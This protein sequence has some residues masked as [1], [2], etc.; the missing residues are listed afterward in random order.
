MIRFSYS[1][2]NT[3]FEFHPDLRDM[4]R[5]KALKKSALT[6]T[7]EDYASRSTIH[8]IGYLFDRGL[9]IVDR[10]LWLFVVVAF[11]S[12]ASALTWNFWSQWRNEQVK[13]LTFRKMIQ[14]SQVVTILNNTTKL[15]EGVPFP[16]L[17]L[18][19]SG[20]HMSN[21]EKKLVQDIIE[22]RAEKKKD[23]T[24]KEALNEDLKEFMKER[25]QIEQVKTNGLITILDILDMM[26]S[27]DPDASVVVNSVRENVVACKQQKEKI[28]Y[29]QM[30]V[31]SCPDQ[32][33]LFGTQCFY[34]SD[35]SEG[36]AVG[37]S[38]CQSLG[39]QLATIR[40]EEEDNFVSS[41]V[42]S[43]EDV[44]IGLIRTN[45]TTGNW[46]WLDTSEPSPYRN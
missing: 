43:S 25:F 18:C 29:N 24:T 6:Q 27:P 8:G 20:I 5:K 31:Y 33:H 44:R 36:Y 35:T 9:G 19:G 41:L 12:I 28:A 2:P 3:L 37:R 40:S 11:L 46:A 13:H 21:V 45:W 42:G 30:C 15:V 16:A 39:A 34:L 23:N 38:T 22:W 7:I 14:P 26:I 17:T 4:N 1:I 32:F 10:L